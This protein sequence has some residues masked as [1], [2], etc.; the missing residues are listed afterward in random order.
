MTKPLH[1]PGHNLY[2]ITKMITDHSPTELMPAEMMIRK[3][4]I[5][6]QI[7]ADVKR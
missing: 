2:P 4:F 5:K 1:I 3:G 7:N 6:I